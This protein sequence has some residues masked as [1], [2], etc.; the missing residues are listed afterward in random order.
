M[1]RTLS[2]IAPIRVLAIVAALVSVLAFRTSAEER[3]QVSTTTEIVDN[4]FAGRIVEPEPT[5]VAPA[6]DAGPKSIKNPFSDRPERPRWISPT[7]PAGPLSRW[8]RP[9]QLPD[10]R[11]ANSRN[12]Q[13]S[14][15]QVERADNWDLL[16]PAELSEQT[17]A[18]ELPLENDDVEQ[19]APPDPT[20]YEPRS[21]DQ[22]M[23]L[24]PEPPESVA[25]HRETQSLSPRNVA[26]LPPDESAE[27]YSNLRAADQSAALS[28]PTTDAPAVIAEVPNP[29][30]LAE[31]PSREIIVS[32]DQPAIAIPQ[33]ARS[34]YRQAE[35]R[36]SEAQ[37]LDE[38]AT[39]IRLCQHGLAHRPPGALSKSLRC[40]AAWACN[41]RGEIKSD[42]RREDEALREFE[43][44]VAWDPNCWLALHNRGISRAQQGQAAAALIDFN[45]TL[46]LNPGLAV[47]YRNRGELLS[48]MGRTEES[49]ADYTRAIEQLPPDAELLDMRGHALHR[50]GR[51]QESLN[52]LNRSI[53][54]APQNP[55]TL[56]HRGN[57]YAELGDYAQA[58]RDFD[59]ALRIDHEYA[60]G[61][62]SV[63]W[64]LATCPNPQYRNP[65]K[66]LS[67]AQKG[68]EYSPPG[69]PF[70]LEAMAAAYANAGQFAPAVRY[71]R[72]A[73]AMAP[74]G[75]AHQFSARLALYERK[76]PF[77]NGSDAT[78]SDAK[79][80]AA[81]VEAPSRPRQ[82]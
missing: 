47:A 6:T 75:F 80:R 54:I 38:L 12:G 43:A 17:A 64:L 70:M 56:T 45:R 39:V 19:S 31:P 65:Q 29:T 10:G 36:A 81:S 71:Q 33:D 8:R 61:Y 57:I 66:A 79:V 11:S 22:P 35:E 77:R 18:T 40:L 21:L 46:Q 24:V 52:D 5:W 27:L 74:A 15:D 50:L 3:M 58:I 26:P 13:A 42:D 67:A 63:A 20:G 59:Q 78:V 25:N 69:D 68:S 73:I 82:Q 34:C 16:S 14:A 7:S 37:S 44:A 62:R 41:R 60:D 53:Q 55:E 30:A 72:E 76:Q 51:Y 23:W 49:V 1:A 4:P 9:V 32:D 28:Y 2:S 48:A